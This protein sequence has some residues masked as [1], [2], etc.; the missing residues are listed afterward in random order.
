MMTRRAGRRAFVLGYALAG[1]LLH[2][3]VADAQQ[4]P[5]SRVLV[6]PFAAEADPQAPGGAAAARWLSEA[7]SVLLSDGLSAR[8]V[9][10]VPRDDRVAVF[11]RLQLPMSFPLTRATTIRVGDLIGASEIIFGEIRAGAEVTVRARTIRLATGK[12]LPDTVG[13]AAFTEML[14]LFARIAGDLRRHIGRGAAPPLDAAVIVRSP[15]DPQAVAR[16]LRAEIAAIDPALPVSI[17]RL[18]QHISEFALRPRFNAVL[19]GIFAGMGLLLA[20]VGVY[21]VISYM[22]GRRTAEIGMRMA[23]GSTPGAAGSR[24]M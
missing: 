2:S 5:G 13:T 22:V 16:W 10:A 14:P 19:V 6:M 17:K 20:A 11:D 9:G 4:V 1:G 15:A 12:H 24:G 8:G 7:A 23:M 21:G 18:E 3:S